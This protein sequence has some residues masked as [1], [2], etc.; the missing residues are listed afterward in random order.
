MMV[1]H[2]AS[3]KAAKTS[4]FKTDF[5]WALKQFK[6]L[7]A[8][9]TQLIANDALEY[10]LINDNTVAD[11]T[12]TALKEFAKGDYLLYQNRNQEAIAQFQ[13]IL[14]NIRDRK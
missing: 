1:A 4:Y 7:K 12:Q 8:A 9:N 6:E 11:S 3:L 10:F 13:S 14:E 5:V 2:E